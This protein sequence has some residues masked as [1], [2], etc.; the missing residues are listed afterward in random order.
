MGMPVIRRG[1]DQNGAGSSL[2]LRLALPFL[3]ALICLVGFAV[4]GM[5]VLSAVRSYVG[6]EGLWSKAQKEAVYHVFRYASSRDPDEFDAYRAALSVPEGD[7]IA[8]EELEKRNP[9]YRIAR[10]GFLKGRNDSADI[11]GM[12][13][14]F[15]RFRSVELVDRS[16]AI[17]AEA[18]THIAKLSSLGDQLHA[19]ID[20]DPPQQTRIDAALAAIDREA[21]I[22]TPLE[23]AFSYSFGQAAREICRWLIELLFVAT[24]VLTTCV[25]WF[26]RV[27]LREREQHQNE[28]SESENRYRTFFETSLDAVILVRQDGEFEAV[29][30]AACTAFGY[31][32]SELKKPNGDAARAQL[33]CFHRAIKETYLTGNFQGHL[34]FQRKDGSV[35]TGEVSASMFSDSSGERKTSIIIRD[36]SA[37]IRA[38]AEIRDLNASLEER[39]VARTAELETANRELSLFNRELESFCYTVSHDLRLPLRSM[40]GF[41]EILLSDY[42]EMLDGRAQDYLHR[43]QHACHRMGRLIDDLLSLTR[44]TRQKLVWKEVDVGV[45]AAQVIEELRAAHP[46]N[47]VAVD[48]VAHPPAATSLGDP[49]LIRVLLQHLLANAWKFSIRAAHP[50]IEFGSTTGSDGTVYFV[51]DNGCGFDIVYAD[52]LFGVFNRLHTPDEFDGTGIGLAIVQRIV[53]RHGGRI[54]ADSAPQEGATFYFTLP[55]PAKVGSASDATRQLS[56]SA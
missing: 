55:G 30:P 2:F 49:F 51:R 27:V 10:D 5:S 47:G 6:G 11:D 44:Y 43:V 37:R 13:D 9:D 25:V 39:V 41:S 54:W 3:L 53:M 7:R 56:A 28:L 45:I 52:K 21:G 22:L 50:Q 4:A 31:E 29:N 34:P 24:A 48:I 38:E 36:V 12:I 42:A 19:E 16:I 32:E 33:D 1:D 17:W 18:D 20:R 14:L 15:R 26:G 8:R 40:N 35:F 23:D 46:G